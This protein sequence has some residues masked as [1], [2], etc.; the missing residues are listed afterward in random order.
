[1]TKLTTIIRR[2][3][4]LYLQHVA[5]FGAARVSLVQPDYDLVLLKIYFSPPD[6]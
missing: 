4:V 5:M 3:A 6:V 1:M 2:F